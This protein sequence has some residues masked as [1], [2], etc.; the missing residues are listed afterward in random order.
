MQYQLAEI[1]IATFREVVACGLEATQ[2]ITGSIGRK[3]IRRA[4]ARGSYED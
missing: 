3:N 2:C 1:N 4:R